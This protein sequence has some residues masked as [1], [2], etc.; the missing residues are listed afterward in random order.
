MFRNAQYSGASFGESF[1]LP[2]F[3]FHQRSQIKLQ[4]RLYAADLRNRQPNGPFYRTVAVD[5]QIV[6]Q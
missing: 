2:F 6:P 5:M 4:I 3:S 1:V